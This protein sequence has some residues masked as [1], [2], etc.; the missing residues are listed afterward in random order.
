MDE[1]MLY[2]QEMLLQRFD[3]LYEAIIVLSQRARQ[4]GNNQLEAINVLQKQYTA[5][6]ISRENLADDEF[7]LSEPRDP[8]ELPHFP[9]P[10]IAAIRE[11]MENKIEWEYIE[12]KVVEEYI[13][14]ITLLEAEI[15]TPKP[16]TTRKKSE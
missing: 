14:A 6:D 4:I 12:Q 1:R 10:T 15:P 11:A 2:S 13:P 5:N 9:K 3:S 16:K 7:D 8:I